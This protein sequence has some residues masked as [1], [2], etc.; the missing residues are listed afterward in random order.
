MNECCGIPAMA[1]AL[2]V[3][4]P[5][6]QVATYHSNGLK[7]Q[8]K[9]LFTRAFHDEFLRSSGRPPYGVS[10]TMQTSPDPA[11]ALLTHLGIRSM[12]EDYSDADMDDACFRRRLSTSTTST[13]KKRPSHRSDD[14]FADLTSADDS[15]PPTSRKRSRTH[16]HRSAERSVPITS[17]KQLA[18]GD[19]KGRHEF[20]NQCFKD[21][22]QSGC[23]VLGKA[24]VKLLEPKKQSTYPYTK[25]EGG[26]P[27]WW[28]PTV[29][30]GSIRH[31]EPDHLHK[32]GK[33]P[34]THTK[35]GV[36]Q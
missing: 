36:N 31:K 19:D 1:Y 26:A 16:H 20:Y 10:E 28:P 23:K 11:C 5:D 25:G 7:T 3:I 22:Q 6:G 21:M 12:Y 34:H 24:W 30:P 4:R 29:G 27:P 9:R 8:P 13:H 18:L 14:T 15:S 32:R 35:R 17:T 2:A 33:S